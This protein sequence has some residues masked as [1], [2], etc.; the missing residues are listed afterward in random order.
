MAQSN[1]KA[2]SSFMATGSGASDS[3]SAFEVDL[4]LGKIEQ[5][6]SGQGGSNLQPVGSE[7][8][9]VHISPV[10]VSFDNGD[11]H[12][13]ST[14]EMPRE[15]FRIGGH[16]FFVDIGSGSISRA[17]AGRSQPEVIDLTND[18]DEYEQ[19]AEHGVQNARMASLR[20]GDGATGLQYAHANNN[21]R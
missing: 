2:F 15:A 3:N 13:T 10:A 7:G 17:P 18:E 21:W 16:Q 20:G 1:T 14:Y 12:N 8:Q 6:S 5:N 4:E 9:G 11:P 19:V